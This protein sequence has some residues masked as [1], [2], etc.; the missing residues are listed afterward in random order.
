MLVVLEDHLKQRT[1]AARTEWDY[2]RHWS[3]KS[4]DTLYPLRNA[5]A[6]RIAMIV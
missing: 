1:L 3:S 5:A 4:L 6:V 2:R